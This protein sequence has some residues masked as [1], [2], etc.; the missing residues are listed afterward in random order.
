MSKVIGG[1]V[2]AIID[3]TTLVLS[4]G[5]RQGVQEGMVFVSFAEQADIAD[6]D[7]GEPLGRW[8]MVKAR[9]VVTHVQERMCTV[10]APAIIEEQVSDG[11]RPLSAR[12]VEHSLGH[13]GEQ[14]EE[15]KRLQVRATDVSGRPQNQPIAVGDGARS[16][17]V[18]ETPEEAPEETPEGAASATA[19]GATEGEEKDA[20]A[21]A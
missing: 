12:M 3:D 11:T 9:V 4:V 2:A 21:E 1:K 16:V 8:E 7:T 14:G 15:W 13:Y 19:E 17:V 5:Y 18:E 6:P 20:S 10:Q